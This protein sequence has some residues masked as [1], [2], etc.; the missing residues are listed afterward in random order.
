MSKLL[1]EHPPRLNRKRVSAMTRIRRPIGA[2]DATGYG[3]GMQIVYTPNNRKLRQDAT[4]LA[5][6]TPEPGDRWSMF[7]QVCMELGLTVRPVHVSDALTSADGSEIPGFIAWEVQGGMASLAM[8][9]DWNGLLDVPASALGAGKAAPGGR[10]HAPESARPPRG[11]MGMGEPKAKPSHSKPSLS[12]ARGVVR[13]LDPRTRGI[14]TGTTKPDR[15]AHVVPGP[16]K[17]SDREHVAIPT[18]PYAHT[19]NPPMPVA[20]LTRGVATW[21]DDV[22][23]PLYTPPKGKTVPV[24]PD[25]EDYAI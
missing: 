20:T 14:L 2:S 1:A 7:V 23:P 9:D 19:T 12:T 22:V 3:I 24:H 6:T 16:M 21:Y 10:Y 4:L 18:L 15:T 8:L 25:L 5:T 13:E 11:G 17:L